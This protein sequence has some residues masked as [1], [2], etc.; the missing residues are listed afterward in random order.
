MIT[1]TP[2]KLA[3]YQ[4]CPLN[5]KFKHLQRKGSFK[6]SPQMAFGTNIHKALEEIYK[7]PH[8]NDVSETLRRC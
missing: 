1:I 3:D 7:T 8:K 6:P 5:F 2:T 4:S